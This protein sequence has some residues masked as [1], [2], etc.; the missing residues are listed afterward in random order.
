MKGRYKRNGI[1]LD[2]EEI[3]ISLIFSNSSV[4]RII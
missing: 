2:Y 4:S 3:D 1:S